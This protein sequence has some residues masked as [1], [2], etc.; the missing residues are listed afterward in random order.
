MTA[1][2][3]QNVA[4]LPTLVRHHAWPRE[5]KEPIPAWEYPDGHARHYR[6]CAHCGLAKITVHAA[7]GRAWREWQ[8][9]NGKTWEGAATP[10]CLPKVDAA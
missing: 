8:H 1:V 5:A 2:D 4:E 9:V 6:I 7:S 3:M 10:P